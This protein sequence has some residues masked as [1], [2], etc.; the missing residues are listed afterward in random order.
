MR[1]EHVVDVPVPLPPGHR[2]PIHPV[3]ASLADPFSISQEPVI[4]E[5]V[6]AIDNRCP[7]CLDTKIRLKPHPHI[8]GLGLKLGS[9]LE[10]VVGDGRQVERVQGL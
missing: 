2:R 10:E 4:D 6:Q 3:V 5:P 9:P 8:H 1:K 7:R